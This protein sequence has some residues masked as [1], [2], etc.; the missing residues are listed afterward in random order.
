MNPNSYIAILAITTVMGVIGIIGALTISA[1]IGLVI[2]F[3]GAAIMYYSLFM[4]KKESWYRPNV[5]LWKL[6]K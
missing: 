4:L 1:P 5:P 2:I 3:S 6:K